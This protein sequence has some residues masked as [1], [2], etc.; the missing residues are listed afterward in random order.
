M[1]QPNPQQLKEFIRN[2]FE[3]FVNRKN[4]DIAEV[5]FAPDFVDR[6]SDVPPGMAA[7]PQGAKQYVGGAL[8]K[9]P[10]MHVTVEDVI[11]E[12]DKVV[13]RN[14]WQGTD[15]DSGKKLRFGGIVIWRVADGKLA[16]RW[17]YLESP[18]VV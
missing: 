12:G 13:V 2:H 14:V 4:L 1:T 15:R 10:D 8:K 6:G 7:G 5:N 3:E 11:V 17:A 18:K 16:E 9:F